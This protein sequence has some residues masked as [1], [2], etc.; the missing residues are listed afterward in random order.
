MEPLANVKEHSNVAKVQEDEVSKNL[1]I[2]GNSQLSFLKDWQSDI[3]ISEVQ[4]LIKAHET[5]KHIEKMTQSIGKVFQ[6]CKGDRDNP[7]CLTVEKM[8]WET[9]HDVASM[10]IQE[11]TNKIDQIMVKLNDLN[12]KIML[13]QEAAFIMDSHRGIGQVSECQDWITL[14][15][16]YLDYKHKV[17]N[18]SINEIKNTVARLP[19]N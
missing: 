16:I 19:N 9:L 3:H 10:I 18:D 6:E 2:T 11:Y 13:W 15:D 12:R 1:Q 5:I 14:K 4:E 17:L 7:L 8:E